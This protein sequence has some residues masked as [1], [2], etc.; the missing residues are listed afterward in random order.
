MSRRVINV[1]AMTSG[2]RSLGHLVVPTNVNLSAVLLC[3]TGNIS[4]LYKH[5]MIA[6]PIS[7]IIL[8]D[9]SAM[10]SGHRS[11]EH[12]VV[13]TDVNLSAVLLYHTVNI[14]ALYKH[15][16]IALPISATMITHVS[17]SY[18]CLGNDQWPWSLEHLVVPTDVN[19]SAVL[20]C[21]TGDISAR[22]KHCTIA[23]PISAII[24]TDVSVSCRRLGDGQVPSVFRASCSADRCES[25]G[26]LTLSHS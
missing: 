23:L 3:H 20:L 14:L 4:A 7:A 17:A 1:S 12:L 22:Y 24:I 2:H 13:P 11:V 5:C 9:V 19:L 16:T 26:G 18:K 15:C 25:L 10:T 21:H 8:I 6:L